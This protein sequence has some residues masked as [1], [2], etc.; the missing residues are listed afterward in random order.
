MEVVWA[1]AFFRTE[2]LLISTRTTLQEIIKIVESQSAKDLCTHLYHEM[3]TWRECERLV[4]KSCWWVRQLR[5]ALYVIWELL[6]VGYYS[7][8][9]KYGNPKGGF[10][11]FVVNNSKFV[12]NFWK[13]I[14]AWLHVATRKIEL[15]L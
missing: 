13:Q 9:E 6:F 1:L 4:R 12:I 10:S 8:L 15:N 14:K 3:S 11:P 2:N 5:V 7:S